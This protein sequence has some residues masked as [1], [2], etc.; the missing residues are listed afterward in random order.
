M[1]FEEM[2]LN[3]AKWFLIIFLVFLIA[4]IPIII[5][6]DNNYQKEIKECYMQEVKT[7]DCKFKL[8]QYEH[9]NGSSSGVVPVPMIIR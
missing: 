2:F 1:D 6:A 8:W 9:R 5:I 4:L 7:K 3:L